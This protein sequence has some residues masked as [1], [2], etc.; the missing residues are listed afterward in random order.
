MKCMNC[1]EMSQKVTYVSLSDTVPNPNGRG[2]SHLVQ[3]CKF[4]SWEGTVT[5][6]PGRGKPLMLDA[7]ESRDYA[8]LMLFDCRGL[9]PVD[10][11]FGQGWKAISTSGT[12]FEDIDLSRGEYADYCE[13]GQIPVMI[14]NLQAKFDAV[15]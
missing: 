5:M 3:K 15:K 1:G 14:S 6:I 7:S 13:K 4:C 12:K 10:Y 11:A 2:T 9:E 8:P